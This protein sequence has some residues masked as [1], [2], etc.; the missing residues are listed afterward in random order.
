MDENDPSNAL[1]HQFRE[2]FLIR[3]EKIENG[4]FLSTLKEI[5]VSQQ[6]TFEE[7]LPPLKNPDAA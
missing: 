3:A 7:T 5:L 6:G 2:Q 4:K 1:P